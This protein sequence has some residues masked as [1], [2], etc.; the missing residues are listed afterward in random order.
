MEGITQ[1]GKLGSSGREGGRDKN[2][3]MQDSAKL[4]LL[5]IVQSSFILPTKGL[6]IHVHNV[7]C[8]NNGGVRLRKNEYLHTHIASIIPLTLGSSLVLISWNMSEG[9]AEWH[10][11]PYHGESKV[12]ACMST[13]L[14]FALYHSRLYVSLSLQ[15]CPICKTTTAATGARGACVVT[16]ARFSHAPLV[17]ALQQA[18][19]VS[20][21]LPLRLNQKIIPC[22]VTV[23]QYDARQII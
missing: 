6:A 4:E 3:C 1:K 2:I 9:V 5:I 17:P 10:C 19:Y 22:L 14:D 23:G 20:S 15:E 18:T 21:N 13:S 11:S 16:T 7:A 12:R 8:H